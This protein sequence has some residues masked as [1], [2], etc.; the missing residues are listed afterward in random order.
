[1]CTRRG[2]KTCCSAAAESRLL[3]VAAEEA[4]D[5]VTSATSS[6]RTLVTD[7]VALYQRKSLN[8]IEIGSAVAINAIENNCLDEPYYINK[9]AQLSLGKTRYSLYSSTD[10]QGHPRS[11][12]FILSEKAYATSY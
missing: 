5:I 1:V 10:F 9:K 8:C 7:N 3:Q 11:I 12:I 6:V 4:R 2:Q